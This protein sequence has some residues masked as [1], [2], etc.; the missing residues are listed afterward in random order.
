MLKKAGTAEPAARSVAKA[1]VR[2]NRD[3][4]NSHGLTRLKAYSA[5]VAVGKVA[6]QAIPVLEKLGPSA[7]RIDANDGFAFPA[8]DIAIDTLVEM[9]SETPVAGI[10]VTNSHHFG[11]A[12]HHVERLAGA[13]WSVWCLATRL[14]RSHRGAVR[15]H[16]LAPT[17]SRSDSPAPPRILSWSTSRCRSRRGAR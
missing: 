3:G 5:Q 7:A 17:R 4:L 12:G 11:V 13:A 8:L 2:A 6:G 10:T 15:A 1:L 9:T 16:C 14:R